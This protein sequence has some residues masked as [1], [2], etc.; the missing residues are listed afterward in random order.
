MI[1][2]E[3]KISRSQALVLLRYTLIIATAYLVLVEHDFS[4]T[5]SGLILLILVVLAS[6]VLVS[7]LPARITESTSFYAGIIIGDTLWITAALVYARLFGA[8]FFYLYFFVLLLAGIGENMGLI[9]VGATVVCIAYVFVVTA[10]GGSESLWS[11]RLLIRIPFL[12]TAAA[13]YG[14]LVDRVRR[15]RQRARE[16]ADTVAY[17]EEVQR[18]LSEHARQLGQANEN[19]AREIAERERA[20][21]AVKAAKDYAESL[22]ES[23]LDMIISTDASRNIVEF[24]Q[25]AED[26]FGYSRAEVVGKPIDL[27]YTDPSDSVTVRTGLQN[28][29]RF[30]GE[31]RNRRKNGESFYAYLSAS[32]MRDA[33]NGIVGGVGVSRDV[34]E[35][36]R[37]EEALK[38]S[39]ERFRK[40]FEEGPLGMAIIDS[41]YRLLKVN[42]ALCQ[43]VGH[44][45]EELTRLALVELAHPKD[46]EGFLRVAGDLFGGQKPS[47]QVETRWIR[48]N[49]EALWIALTASVIRDTEGKP[50]YALAMIEDITE[51]RRA[52][53][54]LREMR[55]YLVRLIEVSADAIISTNNAGDI[56]VF[57]TGA[58]ILLGYRREEIIGR[59]V[60]VIYDSEQRAKDVMRRM[61]QDGGRVAGWET[62]LR[63]HDGSPIPVLLSASILY[64][65][66]GREAGTVGFSKDLRERQRAEEQLR[67]SEERYRTLFEN[68][69]IGLGVADANGTLLAFNNAM[70]EPGGYSR[71]DILRVGNVTHLYDDPD[72]RAIVLAMTQRQGFLHQHEVRFKRKEGGSY[73]ALLSLTPVRIG[74]RLGWQAMVQD[75]TE[76]KRAEDELQNT[77]LQLMQSAKLESVGRLAAGVAHE[78]KNPLAIILQGL[79]YLSNTA[80][81]TGNERVPMVLQKMDDAVK[82]AD[83]VIKG[84]LDF[85]GASAPDVRRASLN[86]VVEDSLLLVNHELVRTRVAVVKKLGQQIPHLK[87]DRQRIEQVFVNLFMN[88]MQAMPDGGTLAV[89]TEV[90]EPREG[91]PGAG[92]RNNEQRPVQKPLIIVEVE[93]TGGGIPKEKLDRIFDPFFTTKPTGQGTGLGLTVSRKIIEL[94]G[95]TME[96][97][98]RKEGGVRVT[99]TFKIED[100]PDEAEDKVPV[101]MT[102]DTRDAWKD[103]PAD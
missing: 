65:A 87:L 91:A 54:E 76:R 66:E 74:G 63:A 96:V 92:R 99:L 95:G 18:E 83:R 100:S 85:S 26:A 53:E 46:T 27:L 45:A 77:Q 33:D 52:E 64:D 47:L 8:E 68:A 81:E 20:E 42:N 5:P 25:A 79:A 15:E 61:R 80:S 43:M 31:I 70:L 57:N 10:S 58:E 21:Q 94:H 50:L 55:Q 90:R 89:T 12:L 13:F 24:N 103:D 51:S 49:G 41:D 37:A 11:S 72:Q 71:E 9:A 23:S 44:A 67:E 7:Q 73:D 86:E 35:R 28:S 98:N 30:A 101:H 69:P 62:I 1:R 48:K 22:I 3:E 29:G 78:V 59:R 17:L 97:S 6:N 16:E 84:L 2:V 56:V 36:R 4:S 39:E 34:T 32:V 14:Y 60:T 102:G 19:L 75:I 38:Q 88:A 93:D 40:I 82:R